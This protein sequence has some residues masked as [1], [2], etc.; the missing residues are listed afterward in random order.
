VIKGERYEAEDQVSFRPLVHGCTVKEM[1][2]AV[3]TTYLSR[4]VLRL[5]N[6]V[7]TP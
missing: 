4:E 3:R 7:R 6:V 5:Y 2:H 1:I